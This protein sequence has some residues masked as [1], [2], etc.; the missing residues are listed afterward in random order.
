[1]KRAGP[2]LERITMSDLTE[3]IRTERLSFID[4][5]ET[6]DE[7]QWRTQSLCSE[8]TVENVAAHLAW[9][10][11]AKPGEMAVGLARSGFRMNKF[12]A[13]SARRWTAR[14]RTAALE[15]LRHNA[16]SNAQPIGL[17]PIAALADAVVHG[18]DVRVPLGLS[19][20]VAPEAF[21]ALADW[22]VKSRWPKTIP[23]G[24]SVR[25]RLP[26]KRLVAVDMGWSWGEGDE[27][28]GTADQILLQLFGREVP[29]LRSERPGGDPGT[30]G[31]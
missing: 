27:V 9:A 12:I 30:P 13:D 6:L 14:G 25:R 16:R 28:R 1:L 10:P 24:G 20:D 31:L 15:Q 23:I 8:W 3:L 26:G 21:T 29:A 5:L 7:Q 17:P 19:S 11:V 18:L 4:L 2:R 22:T